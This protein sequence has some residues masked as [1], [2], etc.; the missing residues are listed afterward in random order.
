MFEYKDRFI[1]TS[2]A[3]NANRQITIVQ[4]VIHPAQGMEIGQF[5]EAT[6]WIDTTETAYRGLDEL[7][8]P[9]FS[10]TSLA[11][12]NVTHVGKYQKLKSK[13]HRSTRHGGGV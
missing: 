1:Y 6:P 8:V 13:F 10:M 3:Q 4:V 7:P 12:G 2:V 9:R 5:V 11:R